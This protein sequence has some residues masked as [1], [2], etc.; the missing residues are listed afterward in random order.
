MMISGSLFLNMD[1]SIK[2]MYKKYILHLLCLLIFWE[3]L[4]TVFDRC[5]GGRE[6]H[7]WYLWMCIGIYMVMPLLKKL[8]DSDVLTKYFLI[9][10]FIFSFII[11]QISAGIGG[12]SQNISNQINAYSG[13]FM[14]Y[15]PLGYTGFVVL[16]Y[17]LAQL[18]PH[19]S[20]RKIIIIQCLGGRWIS[21]SDRKFVI[22][23]LHRS[24]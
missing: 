4:Y 11:S 24:A 15:I 23:R 3:F 5:F 17:Y 7:L 18:Y 6:Y 16:G 12:I 21:Y 2:T 1:I 9:L 19:M 14:V 22:F 20:K 10:S 13:K 8:T